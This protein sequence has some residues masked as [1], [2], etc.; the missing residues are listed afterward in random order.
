MII[1]EHLIIGLRVTLETNQMYEFTKGFA[2]SSKNVFNKLLLCV[3]P[4]III[5]CC[6]A[7]AV[8]MFDVN[9]SIG[10]LYP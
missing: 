9:K 10:E 7:F 8:V 6:A 4:P 3:F 2:K 1:R 5:T